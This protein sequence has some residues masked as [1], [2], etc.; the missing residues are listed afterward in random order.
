VSMNENRG[1]LHYASLYVAERMRALLQRRATEP[2]FDLAPYLSGPVDRN[3]LEQF[4]L[5]DE[6]PA[7]VHQ[8]RDNPQK[9][10]IG[11]DLVIPLDNSHYKWNDAGYSNSFYLQV[12]NCQISFMLAHWDGDRF[13][14][15]DEAEDTC[16]YYG[17][18][19]HSHRVKSS[20][21]CK[22]K[23]WQHYSLSEKDRC[24]YTHGV[25]ATLRADP[26]VKRK[27]AAIT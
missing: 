2:L 11:K 15:S 1:A 26:L 14:D 9:D 16:P 27:P 22:D 18:C 24:W 12:L 20:D 23:P 21:I 25:A 10:Q 3:T 13:K 4:V 5:R 19:N 8:I 6:A 17:A 7:Y